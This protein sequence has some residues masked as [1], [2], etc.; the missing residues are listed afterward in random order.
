[1]GGRA[2]GPVTVVPMRGGPQG[3]RKVLSASSNEARLSEWKQMAS[4]SAGVSG[5]DLSVQT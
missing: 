5:P 2:G 4:A 3:Y 1:V